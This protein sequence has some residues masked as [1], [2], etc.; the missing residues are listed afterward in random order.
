[1]HLRLRTAVPWIMGWGS[2]RQVNLRIDIISAVSCRSI[3]ASDSLFDPRGWV[4]EVNPSDEDIAASVVQICS[5]RATVKLDI[6]SHYSF[7]Q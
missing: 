2:R 4:F 7:C 5:T 1:M 3:T 6:G